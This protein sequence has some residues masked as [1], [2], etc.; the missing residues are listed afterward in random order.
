M[1]ADEKL[2]Q[3][4]NWKFTVEAHSG[5][6][7]PA[8]VSTGRELWFSCNILLFRKAASNHRSLSTLCK[9]L[10]FRGKEEQCIVHGRRNKLRS[11]SANPALA[12]F[13][14]CIA[15]DNAL[16]G[17][18]ARKLLSSLPRQ[19]LT[20]RQRPANLSGRV[21]AFIAMKACGNRLLGVLQSR[22]MLGWRLGA[23]QSTCKA[24]T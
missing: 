15:S 4:R 24:H 1:T 19:I 21:G 10:R 12:L 5:R 23:S 6:D 18:A 3:V 16:V 22:K 13:F 11:R 20:S 9:K 2:L 8:L 14:S 7:L 17:L